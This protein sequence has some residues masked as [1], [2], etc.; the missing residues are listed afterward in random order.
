MPPEEKA[1][2]DFRLGEWLVRPSLG[3]LNG[4]A[5]KVRLEPR[6]MEVLRCL[7]AHAGEVV[8]R[9]K[10]IDAVWQQ[11]FVGDAAVSGAVVKLRGALGDDARSPRFIETVSKRGYRL[12][13]GRWARPRCPRLRRRPRQRSCWQPPAGGGGGLAEPSA[14]VTPFPGV[15]LEPERPVFVGRE[16]ELERLDG[17]LA[18]AL[19]GEGRLAFVTGE[20]GTGKTALV[21]ELVRRAQDAHG[22]LVAAVGVC[23]AQTG[24]GDAYAPWRQL[25]A[26]LTGDVESGL[27]GGSTSAELAR[28]LWRAAPL[29]AEAVV[30]S[31]RDLVGTLIP[32]SALLARAEAAAPAGAPWLEPLRELVQRKAALPPDAALQQAAVFMQA[33]R[34]LGAVARRRPLLLVLEDLHWA[35]AGSIALLF[36]LGR[37]VASHRILLLGTYRPTDVALGRG[38]ERHPLEAVVAE[39]RGRHGRLE[40]DLGQAGDRAFVDAFVDSEPNRLGEGFRESLF[41]QTAG[42]ALFTVE[43][44]RTLQDRGMIVHDP[45]GRWVESDDLDWAAL[46]E[47]VEGVIAARVERLPDEL[48]DLLAVASV[49]GEE[50]HRRGA[51]PGA[52]RRTPGGHPAAQPRAREPPPPGAAPA[53]S[54]PWPQVGCP[55]SASPTC[56]SSATSTAPSTRSSGSSS[57]RTWAPPSRRSTATTP[58]RS[59]SSWRTTSS[60]PG[61]PTRRSGTSSRPARAAS[62]GPPTG[63]R[64]ATSRGRSSCSATLRESDERDRTELALQMAIQAPLIAGVGWGHPRVGE[65]VERARRLVERI[66]DDD[67]RVPVLFQVATLR[68]AQQEHPERH[69]PRGALAGARRAAGGRWPGSS[70]PTGSSA[71]ATRGAASWRGVE[72]TSSEVVSL[73]DERRHHALAFLVGLDPAVA[74][75]TQLTHLTHHDGATSTRPGDPEPPR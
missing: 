34:V 45:E 18:Q 41:R 53:A 62:T 16:A 67:Q 64:S 35:D 10:I 65:A 59:R 38:G 19:A 30:E 48:R 63:R 17:F 23:S 25:L 61:S 39:L 69:R 37:E 33:A 3:R 27:A 21:E 44:L 72:P 29:A 51:G 26:L 42:H 12:V 52:G 8:S 40:V 31:G 54:A 75:L 74:S 49:E 32:G 7:A 70:S 66:G 22:D 24:I 56:S 73:Y 68:G 43:T 47:R 55:S 20:A 60:R 36:H 5:G 46:P 6:A 1:T 50:L 28:R 14:T 57:T 15:R 9:Q 58:R 4:P 2:R 71:S 11:E 13:V